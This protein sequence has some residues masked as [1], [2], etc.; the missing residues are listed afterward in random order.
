MTKVIHSGIQQIY[1]AA[2]EDSSVEQIESPLP[3]ESSSNNPP[4]SFQENRRSI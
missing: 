4:N 1:T 2:S 3:I